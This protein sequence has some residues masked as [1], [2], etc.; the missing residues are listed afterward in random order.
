MSSSVGF[1]RAL[2]DEPSIHY[3]ADE[4]T[5]NLDPGR[6][7]GFSNFCQEIN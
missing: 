3:C 1:A 7:D 6:A 4:P 2:L 5:G